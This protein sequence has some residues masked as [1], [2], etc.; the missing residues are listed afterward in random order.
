VGIRHD[1][2]STEI[3]G[4]HQHSESF[5]CLNLGDSPE[6]NVYSRRSQE[7]FISG[8]IQMVVSKVEMQN[9]RH[10][11]ESGRKGAGLVPIFL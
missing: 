4:E 8:G 10:K 1:M 6:T 2:K 11:Q 7:T 3:T 5:H 9:E